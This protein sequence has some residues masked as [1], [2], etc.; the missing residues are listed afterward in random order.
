M[1]EYSKYFDP[2][3]ESEI[4]PPHAHVKTPKSRSS[5]LE[6]GIWNLESEIGPPHAH[7]K[8]PKSRSSDLESG[9]WNLET[10]I[11]NLESEIGPPHGH[12]KGWEIWIT[13]F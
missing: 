12:F 11:W 8:T 4:G 6:S 1:F 10:L 5:N 2:N 3:L 7:V 13:A 9:I